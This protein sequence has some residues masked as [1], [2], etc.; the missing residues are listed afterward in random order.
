MLFSLEREPISDDG[1]VTDGID[2]VGGTVAGGGVTVGVGVADTGGVCVGCVWVGVVVGVIVGVTVGVGVGDG[3]V[4]VAGWQPDSI[5][6]N[7]NRIAEIAEILR[8]PPDR[9]FRFFDK[10]D[11]FNQAPSA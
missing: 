8:A 10:N 6:K 4:G 7:E 3:V 9:V 1:G 2:G 5:N 11:V